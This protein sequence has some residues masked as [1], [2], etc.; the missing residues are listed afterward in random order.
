MFRHL[1]LIFKDSS[2]NIVVA[3][4]NSLCKYK[5]LLTKV[6]EVTRCKKKSQIE[7]ELLGIRGGHMK[8]Y[9]LFLP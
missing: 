6:A 2:Q 7:T 9:Q 8:K 3:A 1:R 4:R 5:F